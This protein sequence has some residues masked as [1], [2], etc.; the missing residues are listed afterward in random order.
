MQPDG[1]GLR[2][3]IC[4]IITPNYLGQF[5]V[6]GESVART[7]PST[8]LRVLILQDCTDVASIQESIDD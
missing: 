5:L 3:V 1:R 4:A 2:H 6:L 8:D 7:M